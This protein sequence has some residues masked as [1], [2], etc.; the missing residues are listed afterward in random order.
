MNVTTPSCNITNARIGTG[1]NHGYIQD[2]SASQT[3]QNWMTNFVC[4]SGLDYSQPWSSRQ[5][6]KPWANDT[7]YLKSLDRSLDDRILVSTVDF[8]YTPVNSTDIPQMWVNRLTALL[9]KPSYSISEYRVDYTRGTT[10]THMELVKE[11]NGAL[12]N[13]YPGDISKVA[14]E[15]FAGS[16]AQNLYI[17]MGGVDYQFT[18]DA[19]QPFSQMLTLLHGGEQMNFTLKDLMDPE[20]L[21]QS[22]EALLAGTVTQGLLQNVM[23]DLMD[24]NVTGTVSYDKDRLHVKALSTGFLCAG[25]ALMSILS[26]ALIYL[27]PR[28]PNVKGTVGSTLT[29]ATALRSNPDLSCLCQET[30]S[31]DARKSELSVEYF[32]RQHPESGTLSIEFV[33]P[34]DKLECQSSQASQTDSKIEAPHTWWQPICSRDWY[35][36]VAVALCILIIGLLELCQQ[37]SHKHDGFMSIS[38]AGLGSAVLSQ[39]IP[40][41]IVLGVTLMFDDIEMVIATFSPFATLKKGNAMASRTLTLDYLTNSGPHVLVASIINRHFALSLMLVTTFFA[42]FLAIVVPGLYTHHTVLS[43]TNTTLVIADEF[44]FTGVDISLDDK[45]AGV[46]LN[47]LTYYDVGY[48]KWIHNDLA[49]PQLMA[50]AGLDDNDNASSSESTLW[51]RTRAVRAKLS[52][53]SISANMNWTTT[54]G[55]D[56]GLYPNTTDVKATSYLPWSMCSN[57]PANLSASDTTPWA[58]WSFHINETTITRET[59]FVGSAN[60]MN[61]YSNQV[62]LVSGETERGEIV[63]PYRYQLPQWG[64]PSLAFALGTVSFKRKNA[65][66]FVL[67]DP[68]INVLVCSQNLQSVETDVVLYYPSMA[69]SKDY[70]PYPDESTATWL[71]NSTH[72]NGGTDFQFVPSNMLMSLN[73]PNGYMSSPWAPTDDADRFVQALVYTAQKEEGLHLRDLVGVGNSEMYLKMV[74]RLYGRYMAQAMSN[75]MRVGVTEGVSN[76][77]FTDAPWT[78]TASPVIVPTQAS[79]SLTKTSNSAK[80]LTT[81]RTATH[82]SRAAAISST[83]EASHQ[84]KR[85]AGA[86]QTIPATL[87]RNGA[88]AHVRLK[89]NRAP[90][91]ALQAILA[92][93][94]VGAIIAKLLLRTKKTLQREPYSISGRAVLVAS[95]DMLHTPEDDREGTAWD[96]KMYRLGWWE[97]S[98]GRRRYGIYV[99]R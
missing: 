22:A 4:N 11:T 9:C 68:D 63:R 6:E 79:S 26:I 90:K 73:N 30:T 61:W 55:T 25:F 88:G 15:I 72:G 18:T 5:D 34:I 57:P 33:V 31:K 16:D 74:Q 8:H 32:T 48:P 40:A 92:F 52:C 21:K 56:G 24:T 41:A 67:N 1:P 27:A 89:Q 95:G 39:Y 65:T 59:Y 14:L 60:V 10:E 84:R 86:E 76:M 38:T 83:T 42:S 3:Y 28:K 93:M 99:E 17:G 20:V 91:I 35:T 50:T 37:L 43:E 53:Q 85:A 19:V 2:A 82:L 75:N 47:L 29:V 94:A 12:T 80:T 58:Q 66:S 51:T 45:R 62:N 70:P 96:E 49:F 44:K 77:T 64:C 81:T 7:T 36:G 13:F 23:T 97:D 69:I 71:Q 87:I 78:P 98:G 54:I 46:N